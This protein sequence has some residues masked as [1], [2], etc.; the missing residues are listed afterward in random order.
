MGRPQPG[1]AGEGGVDEPDRVAGRE[2]D[3]AD[4]PARG[5]GGIR[6]EPALVEQPVAREDPRVIADHLFGR[7]EQLLRRRRRAAW[8]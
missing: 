7:D 8:R 2:H 5:P 1:L 3:V 6:A 4:A